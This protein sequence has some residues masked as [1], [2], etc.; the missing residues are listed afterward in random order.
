MSC[1]RIPLLP[2]ISLWRGSDFRIVLPATVEVDGADVDY[3]ATGFLQLQ[4]RVLGAETAPTRWKSSDASTRYLANEF[5]IP[6]D[7]AIL[8][9]AGDGDVEY[10][11]D[12][13]YF[14]ASSNPK[15]VGR[16]GRIFVRDVDTG[17]GA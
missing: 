9:T 11:Y 4:Y 16:R 14:D 13:H 15:L 1:Q 5:L 12:V 8:G 2:S 6:D 17:M 10:E 3:E 7:D